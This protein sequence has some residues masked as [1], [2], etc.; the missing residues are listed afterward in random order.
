MATD[1]RVIVVS[2]LHILGDAVADG[3][4]HV[5][6]GPD[7]FDS[8]CE[9]AWLIDCLD[10]AQDGGAGTDL[11]L[12]LN[13]DS[14][15]FPA[16][17]SADALIGDP[18]LAAVRIEAALNRVPQVCGALSRFLDSHRL[19]VM[20][21]DRDTQMVLPAAGSRFVDVLGAREDAVRFLPDSEPCRI[22]RLWIEHGHAYDPWSI[23]DE[24]GVKILRVMQRRDEGMQLTGS[25]LRRLCILLKGLVTGSH[26]TEAHE[27]V[28]HAAAGRLLGRQDVDVVVFGHTHRALQVSLPGG[29]YMNTGTWARRPRVLEECLDDADD[30]M[31]KF[32][33]WIESLLN[34]QFDGWVCPQLT[35]ADIRLSRTGE[36]ESACF[37]EFRESI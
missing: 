18:Q 27:D 10:T 22:G 21:G 28:Y 3:R 17:E 5:W 35:Y 13:G 37:C 33:T 7:I 8:A 6:R 9:L 23:I 2:D 32:G 20:A 16:G 14:F 4:S 1:K 34:G 30:A 12:V 36:V 11:D 25:D 15:D 26:S 29:V 24:N 19:T 31:E